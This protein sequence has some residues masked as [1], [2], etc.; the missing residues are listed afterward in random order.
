MKKTSLWRSPLSVVGVAGI[1]A[2]GFIAP[3][4]ASAAPAPAT[5]VSQSVASSTF[6][7]KISRATVIARA[8]YWL[9][10]KVP[11]SQSKYH[12]DVNHS[13]AYRQDCSGFVSMAWHL[14]NSY[15]TAASGGVVSFAHT[16]SYSQLKPGDTLWHV[17]HMALFHN[18]ANA[19]H[20]SMVVWEESMPGKPA[21]AS[22]WGSSYFHTYTPKAFNNITG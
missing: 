4:A 10:I 7:G 18:W 14:N 22:T 5:S 2:V 1:L 20:T 21:L 17:G 6:N 19:A 8:K 9:D 3:Q 12:Y 16:I 15:T 11:Y 13:K